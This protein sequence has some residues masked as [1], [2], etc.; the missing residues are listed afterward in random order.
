M[1]QLFCRWRGV[2]VQTADQNDEP[3]NRSICYGVTT[4]PLSDPFFASSASMCVFRASSGRTY[5]YVHITAV[6]TLHLQQP[7][8]V[9]Q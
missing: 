8:T 9:V 6:A 4:L 2:F 3:S 7:S 5:K 1:W